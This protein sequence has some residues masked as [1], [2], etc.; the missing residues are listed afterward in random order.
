MDSRI[1]SP[2]AL[3]LYL[4]G[5]LLAIGFKLLEKVMP[6]HHLLKQERRIVLERHI[7]IRPY[8]GTKGSGFQNWLFGCRNLIS[9]WIGD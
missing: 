4:K 3:D 1:Q 9:L 2:L 7:Y 8:A 6:S 5:L